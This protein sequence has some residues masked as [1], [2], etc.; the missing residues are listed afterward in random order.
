MSEPSE[1]VITL[2][3]LLGRQETA[4]TIIDKTIDQLLNGY[5]SS[6]VLMAL[7]TAA[8][9]IALGRAM[10]YYDIYPPVDVP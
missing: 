10:T 4:T 1:P 3:E 2:D 7:L 6:E 8:H 5:A 9:K